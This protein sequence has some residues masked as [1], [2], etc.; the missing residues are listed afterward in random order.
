MTWG[1][2]SHVLERFG[3]AG[4]PED[5]TRCVRDTYTF[6]YPHPPV[7]LMAAFRS[8][9][10]PK[11][12]AFEAAEKNGRAADLQKELVVLFESQNKSPA[13]E[14]TSIPATFLRVTVRA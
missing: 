5:H 12:N 13:P 3:A 11:M 2:E 8:Y 4:V 6:K 14:T 1:V 9:Y 7:K 10:G